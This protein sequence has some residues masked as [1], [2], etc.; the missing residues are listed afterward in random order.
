[1]FFYKEPKLI[2]LAFPGTYIYLVITGQKL[3]EK[4][5]KQLQRQF[6]DLLNNVSA[7]LYS[8]Y[9]MENSFLRAKKEIEMI[10]GEGADMRNEIIKMEMQL[11]NNVQLEKIILD[12]G[13]RSGVEDIKT[14]SD[15]FASAKRSGGNYKEMIQNICEIITVKTDIEQEISTLIAG[16]MME[17]KIMS[18][19]PFGIV[20]YISMTSPGYFDSLYHNIFGISIMTVCLCIYLTSVYLSAKI[21]DI[22]V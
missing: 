20:T 5:K 22:K 14:F 7:N 19:I 12:L 13:I 11:K 15:V 2:I 6:K 17:Q 10:Y 1:M 3:C 4:R 18:L 16:K 21:V 9:S 8:G